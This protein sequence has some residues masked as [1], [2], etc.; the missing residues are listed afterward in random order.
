MTA[1]HYSCY[2]GSGLWVTIS[3]SWAFCFSSPKEV[4]ISGLL[5]KLLRHSDPSQGLVFALLISV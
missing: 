5:P 1:S 4:Q 2:T 3:Y